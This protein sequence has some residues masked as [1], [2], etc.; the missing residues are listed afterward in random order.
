[1]RFE[2]KVALVTGAGQ[3]IGEAYAKA[4]AQEGASIVIAEIDGEQGERVAKE[5]SAAGGQALF[6]RTDVSSEEST[7][8]MARAAKDA[9]GGVDYLIN[10]AAIYG[11]MEMH[12]LLTVPLDYYKRF[13]SVNMD[14]CLLVTRAIYE[15]MVERGGGAIVNQSS[16][17]AWMGAG[18]YG[19]AKLAMHGITQSLARELGPRN[20]RVNAIAP[21]PTDTDATRRIVPEQILKGILMTMPLS[22]IGETQDMV[23]PALFLL[24][25]EA[26]W[27]TGQILAVDGG[28]IMRV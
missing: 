2:N 28:Q 24:S 9:F 13:M 14:G 11:N 19:I 25:D 22:R 20:I 16:A 8:A 17:A 26:R 1:M 3:G 4:L 23:G 5:I 21:G 18:Y 7:R 10:N 6:V 15:S 27:I 12:S